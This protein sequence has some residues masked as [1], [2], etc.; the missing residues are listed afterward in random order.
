[1]TPKKIYV[2]FQYSQHS[3]L[4]S[5]GRS[6][7]INL[8]ALITIERFMVIAYPIRSRACFSPLKARLQVL[9]TVVYVILPLIPRYTSLYVGEN[10]YSNHEDGLNIPSLA[11]FEYIFRPT[12][13]HS[14]WS[15]TLG[16][17]F[18]YYLHLFTFCVPHSILLV[19]NVWSVMKVNY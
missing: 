3:F 11:T 14:F 15:R 17:S 16:D 10:I 7:S 5:A 13:L 1:M 18:D 2:P 19:F 6:L 9:I 12:K 8:T 4:Y